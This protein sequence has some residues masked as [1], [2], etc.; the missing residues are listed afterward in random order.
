MGGPSEMPGSGLLSPVPQRRS[1]QRELL[2]QYDVPRIVLGSTRICIRIFV[3]FARKLGF[4]GASWEVLGGP[5][6]LLGRY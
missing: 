6:R 3:D 4:R 5:R 2:M 1:A